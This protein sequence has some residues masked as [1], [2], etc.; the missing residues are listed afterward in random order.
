[1]TKLIVVL[2]NVVNVS[3]HKVTVQIIFKSLTGL[4]LFTKS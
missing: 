1:M 3:Q 2:H 4:E